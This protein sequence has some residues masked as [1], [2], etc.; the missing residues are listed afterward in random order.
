VSIIYDALQKTQRNRAAI[1]DLYQ[2]KMSKRMQFLDVGL[3]VL[4]IGLIAAVLFAYLPRVYKHYSVAKPPVQV[5]KVVAVR[6]ASPTPVEIK[7]NMVLNGVMLSDQ[8]KIALINNQSYHLGEWVDGMQIVNI[9]LNQV[10]LQK[11]NEY[12]VLRTVS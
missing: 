9:Q 3:Y 7:T 4:I 1:R 11:D 5:E 8:N 12:V 2:E 6:K 10:K